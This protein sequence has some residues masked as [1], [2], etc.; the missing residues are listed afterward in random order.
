M[1]NNKPKAPFVNNQEK[2]SL[3]ALAVIV[4]IAIAASLV[5]W[6]FIAQPQIFT[7]KLAFQPNDLILPIGSGIGILIT[8]YALYFL[9]KFK[10]TKVNQSKPV[11]S[12]SG[13]ATTSRT[14]TPLNAHKTVQQPETNK[15]ES[16]PLNQPVD[17][18]IKNSTRLSM[19]EYLEF[20][21]SQN[22]ESQSVV[23]EMPKYAPQNLLRMLNGDEKQAFRLYEGIYQKYGNRGE[24]WIWEKVIGDLERDR[25]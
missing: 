4:M 21:H 6:L 24:K 15:K 5:L 12:N 14:N 17:Q 22:P 11:S 9:N 2:E 20:S 10:N 1:S 3:A 16:I 19:R 23:Y 7:F 18:P 13:H 8:I 25:R